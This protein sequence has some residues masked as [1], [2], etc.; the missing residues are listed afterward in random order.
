MIAAKYEKALAGQDDPEFDDPNPMAGFEAQYLNI[1]KVSETRTVGNPVVTPERWEEL[2]ST[3][4]AGPPDAVAVEAWFA[5]GVSVARAWKAAQGPVAVSV[6][7][8]P[9]LPSAA[10]YVATLAPRRAVL[11]GRSLE[12]HS[13]WRDHKL[14]V[15]GMAASTRAAVGDLVRFLAEGKFRHDGSEELQEQVLGLRVSPG[16]DGPRIRSTGRGDAIKAAVWAVQEA[17][18]ISKGQVLPSRYR[19]VA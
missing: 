1:W 5:D 8:F 3:V 16:V 9:D 17:S 6:D 11:V 19:R 18:V 14:R 15:K 13:A 4:P 7:T 12:D 10:A 2:G